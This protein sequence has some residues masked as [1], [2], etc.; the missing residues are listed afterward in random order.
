MLNYKIKTKNLA[1]VKKTIT[2]LPNIKIISS[3]LEK[4]NSAFRWLICG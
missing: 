3:S 4:I 2:F 1:P